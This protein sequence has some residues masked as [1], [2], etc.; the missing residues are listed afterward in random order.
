MVTC[1]GMI[2][3]YGNFSRQKT[4]NLAKS[5]HFQKKIIQI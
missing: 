2:S 3:N 4:H 1:F 5:M